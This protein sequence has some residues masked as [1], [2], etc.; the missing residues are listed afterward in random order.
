VKV[1]GKGSGNVKLK[2]EKVGAAERITF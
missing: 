1:I 2:G